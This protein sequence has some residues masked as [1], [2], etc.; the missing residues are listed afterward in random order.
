MKKYNPIY[1]LLFIL[2]IMGAFA[3]MA[4]N[5]YGMKI[6][7]GVAFIF[8]FVFLI[9]FISTIRKEGKKDVYSL[10]ESFCL[11]V[12]AFI[13]G[14]RVF[15]IHFTFIE[16]LF[17][18]TAVLLALIYLRKMII[19]FRELYPKNRF[20][21]SLILIFHLGIILFFVSMALTPFI[22]KTAEII[23]VGA[24]ILL[25]IF[26]I[27]GLITRE[28]LIEGVNFSGFS[29]V[30]HF[31]DHSLVITSIFVLFSLYLGLNRMGA[32]PAVYSDEYPKAYFEL[33][34]DATSKKEKAVNGKYK[35]EEFMEK[36]K[37]FL[38]NAK[39]K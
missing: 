38:K 13:F 9:E 20:L 19:R 34:N 24:F 28:L 11:F 7:G 37:E 3:S 25:L 30:R 12:L 23:G 29:L 10:L 5:S 17:T 36:Y 1:Y 21:G 14:L 35:Y 33:V 27:A 4:Q 39:V 18:L 31:K 15:Y 2:L 8:A 26:I 6:I 32:I 22:P 16:W